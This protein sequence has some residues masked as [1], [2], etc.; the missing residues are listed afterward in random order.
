MIKA[1]ISLKTSTQSGTLVW[2]QCRL[3]RTGIRQWQDGIH[4]FITG[5]STMSWCPWWTDQFLAARCKL[6]PWLLFSS[7]RHSGTAAWNSVSGLCSLA[8][9]SW[10]T[11]IG[12]AQRR[13]WP[14]GSKRMCLSFATGQSFGFGNTSRRA[15]SKSRSSFWPSKSST[16]STRTYTTSSTG[17]CLCFAWLLPCCQR[18]KVADRAALPRQQSP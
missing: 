10:S 17:S 6:S 11:S 12:W 8:C 15:I 2:W 4:P 5:S 14:I 1:I 16:T 9:S 13:N 7:R 3:R 18:S